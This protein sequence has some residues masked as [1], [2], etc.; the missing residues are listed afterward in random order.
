M[1]VRWHNKSRLQKRHHVYRKVIDNPL[2]LNVRFAE[3]NRSRSTWLNVFL[4]PLFALIYVFF[5]PVFTPICVFFQ[6]SFGHSAY[7]PSLYFTHFAYFPRFWRLLYSPLAALRLFAHSCVAI[8]ADNLKFTLNCPYFLVQAP[9]RNARLQMQTSE[10]CWQLVP[11]FESWCVLLCIP[12]T[13]L[14][15]PTNGISP[16]TS[17]PRAAFD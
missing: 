17:Y 3:N 2:H 1:S 14:S 4:Q 16:N 13:R 6:P 11:F 9:A 7:F 12:S 10:I 5:Q 15:I 8:L